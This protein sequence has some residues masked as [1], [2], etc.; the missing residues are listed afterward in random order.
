MCVNVSTCQLDR[1]SF[2]DDVRRALRESGIEPSSLTLEITETAL[3]HDATAAA[4]RL[5]EIKALGVR[6]AIDD[7]GT[8][9][10]SLSYLRQ[11]DVD[12]IKIDRSFVS[13]MSES[14]NRRRSSTR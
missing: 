13:A 3:M 8:G 7:F 14:A 5:D 1:E 4:K 11:F 9:S 10:S 2:T 6:I 12:A